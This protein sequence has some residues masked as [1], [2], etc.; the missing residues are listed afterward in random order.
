MKKMSKRQV[1]YLVLFI[2]CVFVMAAGGTYA[3]L[4]AS[5]SSTEDSVQ[6]ESTT[7]SI[8][9]DLLPLYSD[10]S[11]I[12][13]NDSDTVKALSNKCRDKYDRGACSAYKIDIYGYS[14]KL[15]FI[16]GYMDVTTNNMSNLSYMMYRL[17]DTFNEETCVKLEEKNYCIA[18]E[19]RPVGDGVELSLGDKYSV[20]GMERTE[21]ILLFWLSNL[22][23]SQNVTDIG[24]F[25]AEVTMQAGNGGQIKGVI[26]SAV[27]VPG[28]GVQYE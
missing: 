3:Y 12:P 11:F 10:F 23:V 18:Q 25:E 28:E 26:S 13:M 15:D 27:V 6:T 21:F 16:S 5:T 24:S 9:M 1:I 19:A 7:Y 17:S 4:A 22:E 20:F 8:S 2:V 14:N